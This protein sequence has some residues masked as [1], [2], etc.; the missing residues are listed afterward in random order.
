MNEPASE[1][2]LK[3]EGVSKSF[4][5]KVQVLD[6]CN[7]IVSAGESVSI[8]GPSGSGKSTLLHIAATLEHPDSGVV[9]I[10]GMDVSGLNERELAGLRNTKIGFVFQDHHLLSHCTVAENVMLPAVADRKRHIGVRGYAE[11]LLKRV[12]LLERA[13][14]FPSNLSGGQRQRVAVVRALVNRPDLVLADEPTGS[15]D[16][17]RAGEIA[18]LL[19]DLASETGTAIV[20]V[21]H[22]ERTAECCSK[23]FEL[24]S[25]RLV[26][27]G[28]A[29]S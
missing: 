29:S 17:A 27:E 14:D 28:N 16:R 3:I 15:L 18:E 26:E 5:E 1:V 13:D 25:G 24:V 7:L 22:D 8:T 12:G 23:R 2:V 6:S 9:E 19:I 10:D 11:E 21:T 4:E 20:I